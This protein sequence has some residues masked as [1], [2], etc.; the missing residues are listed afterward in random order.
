M[1]IRTFR[2]LALAAPLLGSP[3]FADPSDHFAWP[4]EITSVDDQVSANQVSFAKL[5][6]HACQRELDA[7]NSGATGALFIDLNGDGK[8]ELIVDDGLGGPGGPGYRVYRRAHGSWKL[9][10]EFQG[11]LTLAQKS[12]GYDQLEVVSKGDAGATNKSLY[13]FVNGK[14]R[15]VRSENFKDGQF[16]RALSPKELGSL[17]N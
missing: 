15:A 9:I 7:N 2:L 6:L 3:V 17:N 1:L 12:N 10:G 4:A 14:Y 5:P 8:K 11:S 13:R 16:V